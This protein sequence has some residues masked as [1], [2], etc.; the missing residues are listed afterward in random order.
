MQ[1]INLF[2]LH[3]RPRRWVT[4]QLW[5]S[6]NITASAAGWK[7][8]EWHHVAMTWKFNAEG[9][10][11][12][13]LYVDRQLVRQMIDQTIMMNMDAINKP[14]SDRETNYL[15][16]NGAGAAGGFKMDDLKIYKVKREY[17]E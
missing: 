12:I 4:T 6:S 17:T 16:L 7:A 2:L 13:A 11:T 15:W 5:Y 10:S 9:K 1:Y 8:N 3:R 14:G